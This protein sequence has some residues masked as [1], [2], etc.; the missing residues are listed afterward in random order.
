MVQYSIFIS[1]IT[2]HPCATRHVSPD[3]ITLYIC[4]ANLDHV[5]FLRVASRSL[6]PI[7][8]I[9][10]SVSHFGLVL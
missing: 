5:N 1:K 8:Q 4:V 7:K 6:F 3:A 10:C 9:S 2:Q